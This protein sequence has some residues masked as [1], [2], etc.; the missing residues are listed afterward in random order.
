MSRIIVPFNAIQCLI[1]GNETSVFIVFAAF[2]KK[3]CEHQ[4]KN[5]KER[6]NNK[7]EGMF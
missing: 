1:F 4:S 5:Q 3:E 6:S 2:E 7:F